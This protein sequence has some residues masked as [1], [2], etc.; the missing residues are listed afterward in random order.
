MTMNHSRKG[1][2]I[3][4]LVIS[5]SLFVG[6]SA[7]IFS[8]FRFG[9][10]SFQEVNA[11]H[12]LQ[13]DALRIVESLQA[14]MKRTAR[15]SELSINDESREM[16][17][18]G[19]TVKRDVVSFLGLEDW[20]DHTNSEN[21]DLETSAPNWNRYLVFYATKEETGRFVRLKIDPNPPPGAPLPLLQRDLDRLCYDEPSTNQYSG[22]SPPYVVL[23]KNVYHFECA[24]PNQGNYAVS[25]KLREKH[26]LGATEP[27]ARRLF[28]Y[29]ELKLNIR[30]EN[31]FPN[32]I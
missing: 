10:R 31:S 28:D 22:F 7:L 26:K 11:K 1:F 14:E 30:P 2:S 21:F 27:G 6:L 5:A 15:A 16:S 3:L 23:A 29:Y 12:G 32:D 17:I 13:N 9:T 18:D 20:R 4:E 8:F 25:L 24:D 19:E